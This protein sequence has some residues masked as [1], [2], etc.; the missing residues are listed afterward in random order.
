MQASR[1]WQEHRLPHRRKTVGANGAQH[2]A[3]QATTATAKS[4]IRVEE[5]A[6]YQVQQFQIP[7]PIRHKGA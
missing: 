7:C 2:T 4:A 6:W 1:A 3:R 5:A